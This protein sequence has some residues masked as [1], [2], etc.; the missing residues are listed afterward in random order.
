MASPM[1]V[2]VPLLCFTLTVL[3]F[4]KKEGS[5]R[6]SFLC[7]GVTW[8]LLLTLITEVLSVPRLLTFGGVLGSWVVAAFAAFAVLL[9]IRGQMKGLPKPAHL[10]PV[11]VALLAC[12]AVTV[13]AV[14]LTAFVAAPNNFDS[15]TYHLSR[16]V[17]WI[18]N[19]S[20]A[21]YPTHITRQLHRAPWAEFAI[22]HLQML[23]EGDR[24]ANLVQWFSMVGSIL[25]ATLIARQLG[26]DLRGQT[27]TAVVCATIPMGIAQASTAQNDYVVAFWLVC[28]AHFALAFQQSRNGIN[29]LGVGASLGLALLTKA[30]AYLYAIP[31]LLWFLVSAVAALR[32][33]AWKPVLAAGILALSVNA[34]HFARN[35][36][37]YGSPLGVTQDGV[38]GE[39]RYA[40]EVFSLPTF[41]SNVV[42]NLALQMGTPSRRLNASI[43]EATHRVH[44]LL[45]VDASDRRTT[46]AGTRFGL[47]RFAISE[48]YSFNPI[49]ALLILAASAALLAKS[50]SRAPR[51]PLAYWLCVGAGFLLFC[52]YLKWQP[53]H[54]RLHLPS[55]VLFSPV[56]A[57]ALSWIRNEKAAAA[58]A[59]LLLIAAL[60]W[61]L[62]SRLRPL[63]G[64]RSIFT[65]T[66]IDQFFV[67][68][69]YLRGPCQEA[70]QFLTHQGHAH[71]GL[72]LGY[73]EPEYLFWVFF[74]RARR[75]HV[76]IEHVGVA[77]L[78][79]LKSES[80]GHF[81]PSAVICLGPQQGD[82]IVRGGEPRP[83]ELSLGPVRVF[84]RR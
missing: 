10:S 26:A 62:S 76:R 36:D 11:S 61:V 29:G 4:L 21:F 23:S 17:H 12:V 63:I 14:G 3:S 51:I 48:D 30:T 72:Y 70:V 42:R 49:H 2:I 71:I 54:S 19:R 56:V 65:T 80:F 25:G 58:V 83:S 41:I 32:R 78:S 37:L 40:N 6:R 73:D 81:N 69:P 74:Q 16:V 57:L 68:R 64:P 15:L 79:A 47:P 28:L 77:N 45:G 13:S 60:P 50:R 66:R 43:E 31:F 44:A 39:F 8:G 52:F 1:L 18:Q 20:V 82:P 9:S 7:A 38:C 84:V 27:L 46:L 67:K 34:G 75:E 55:L 24:W 53:W 35:W 59:I 33:Q 5:W 22:L